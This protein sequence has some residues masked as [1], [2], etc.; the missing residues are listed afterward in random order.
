MTTDKVVQ[1]YHDRMQRVLD[2][3]DRHADG[4]LDL[5]TL[6]AIAAFSKY[7]FHRQFSSIFGI[8]IGRYV[9]LVRLK[10]ASYRLAFRSDAS[11][12]EIALDA[13]YDSPEAFARVFRQRFG[14]LPSRFRLSPDWESWLAALGPLDLARSVSMQNTP[15]SLDAVTIADRA[16]T[17]VAMMEHRGDPAMLG[18]TIQRFI[19]WRKA[20]G[21]PPRANA[22]FTIFHCDPRTTAAADYQ[23]SLCV[24]TDRD[25]A[26][27]EM[28]V[29]PGGRRAVLRVVGH[30]DDLEPAAL[31][32][33]RDW[34]PQ[35]GEEPGDFPLYAERV[36][37]FP[38]VPENEAI[39]D[40][41]LP[42]RDIQGR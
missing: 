5:T 29:I 17:P 14:Q 33:Y 2:H 7:H 24:A 11:V 42:L 15:F 3:I 41:Y 40:L 26:G 37:F 9:Q 25:I 20:N 13:G 28:G 6:S 10:R 23:L 1:R 31:F 21:L 18:A 27:S 22:T 8:A 34:L 39:T 32:L 4:D 35:S 16:P 38:D 36:R 12:T 19:A 30:S